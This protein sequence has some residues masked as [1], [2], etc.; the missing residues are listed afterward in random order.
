MINKSK[1]GVKMNNLKK[2][3][4]H[5]KKKKK[6]DFSKKM[7]SFKINPKS[8]SKNK[9]R[10][11]TGNSQMG[12]NNKAE[13]ENGNKIDLLI[14]EKEKRVEIGKKEINNSNDSSN[15]KDKNYN[16]Y[17]IDFLTAEEEK[18]IEF[19]EKV[20][21]GEIKHSKMKSLLKAVRKRKYTEEEAIIVIKNLVLAWDY[22]SAYRGDFKLY[23]GKAL[24]YT[25]KFVKTKGTLNYGIVY[26]LYKTQFDENSETLKKGFRD[27]LVRHMLSMFRSLDRLDADLVRKVI[28]NKVVNSLNKNPDYRIYTKY[29]LIINE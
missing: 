21:S 17:E 26:A 18:C 4:L 2:K 3:N 11:K 19:G 25:S 24:L 20:M 5:N 28:K 10:L 13:N 7:T 22:V 8:K 14:V 12:L 29:G 27:V 23:C 16:D 6:F 15:N 1:K 9:K